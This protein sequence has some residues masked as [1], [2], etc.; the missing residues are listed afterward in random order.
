MFYNKKKVRQYIKDKAG[1]SI[2][3]DFWT[4]LN[5]FIQ[6]TLDDAIRRNRKFKRI[7]ASELMFFPQKKAGDLSLSEGH[8]V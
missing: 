7:T 2:S 8:E 6:K 4:A 3:S 5:I 1:V